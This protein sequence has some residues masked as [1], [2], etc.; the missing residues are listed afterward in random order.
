M[1]QNCIFA[2]SLCFSFSSQ[3]FIFSLPK[4]KITESEFIFQSHLGENLMESTLNFWKNLSELSKAPKYH[5]FLRRRE[6]Q[7][8]HYGLRKVL[9]CAASKA[10]LMIKG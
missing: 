3:E 2:P 10:T 6:G 5:F 9:R 8:A 1:A 4:Q 7:T